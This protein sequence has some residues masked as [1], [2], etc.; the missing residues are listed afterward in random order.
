[1]RTYLNSFSNFDI[2][3]IYLSKIT[4]EHQ[5]W[6]GDWYQNWEKLDKDYFISLWA[7]VAFGQNR[8]EG[9]RACDKTS[10]ILEILAASIRI[11]SF[12][13][14]MLRDDSGSNN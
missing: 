3:Y 9:Y 6:Q 8:A 2:S 14:L 5:G 12:S 7:R 13:G 11:F 1:M 4:A 10:R